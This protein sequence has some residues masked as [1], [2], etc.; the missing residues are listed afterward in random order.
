MVSH[1]VVRVAA[2]I[3]KHWRAIHASNEHYAFLIAQG[4]L[5]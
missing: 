5:V 4:Q 2:V 1:M 3:P